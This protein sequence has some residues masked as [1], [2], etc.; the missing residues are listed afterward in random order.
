MKS[1]QKLTDTSEQSHR[2]IK[3]SW[4]PQAW[5]YLV[6][7][8]VGHRVYCKIGYSK[9]PGSRFS[10]ILAG[11]PEQP[12]RMHLLCCLSV[13]QARLFETML[14]EHLKDYRARGEWFTHLN[15]KHLGKKL[16]SKVQ[17]IFDLFRV[18]GYEPCLE[19]IDLDGFR[20]VLYENGYI[21]HLSDSAA[22][23]DGEED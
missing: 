10:Q 19:Q 12:F 7:V 17:E 22:K 23:G 20:P 16:G 9:H 13:E 4:D 8:V 15:V 18:F 5:V 11:I 1:S 14:H 6:W 21:S 2:E 3:Y